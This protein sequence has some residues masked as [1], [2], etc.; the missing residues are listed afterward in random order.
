MVK[1]VKIATKYRMPVTPYSG[2][3]SLE[4]NCRGVSSPFLHLVHQSTPWYSVVCLRPFVDPR[5]CITFDAD[6]FNH[7]AVFRVLPLS[8]TDFWIACSGWHLRRHVQ[9]GQ[10]S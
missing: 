6:F 7:F 9:H 5:E 1:I 4:G 10:D 3:T 8:V 2:G